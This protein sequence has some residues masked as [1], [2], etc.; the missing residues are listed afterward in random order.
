M[1]FDSLT[2]ARRLKTAGFPEP[3]ADAYS[4]MLLPELVTKTD[5]TAVEQKLGQRIDGVE[6]KL[7]QR[8]DAVVQKL[9]QMIDGVEQRIESVE[10]KLEGSIEA[11]GLRMTI[12]LGAMI[13]AAVA[14]LGGILRL[15]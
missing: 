5:L 11:L 10:R 8:I 12:R 15:H 4:D 1:S 13:A 6:Q 9:G 3:Q 7:G 2:F 14:I